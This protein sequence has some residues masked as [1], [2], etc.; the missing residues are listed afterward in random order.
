MKPYKEICDIKIESIWNI[1]KIKKGQDYSW[2]DLIDLYDDLFSEYEHLEE[3]FEDFK[4]N[5][6]ENY[7]PISYEEQIGYNERDFIEEL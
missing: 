2:R 4:Q 5:V 6:E 3:E 7:K 1:G